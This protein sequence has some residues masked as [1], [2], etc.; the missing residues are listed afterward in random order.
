MRI[1]VASSFYFTYPHLLAAKGVC[2][3]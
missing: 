1:P 2:A 3:I